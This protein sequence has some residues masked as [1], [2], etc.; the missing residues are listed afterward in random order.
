[1]QCAGSFIHSFSGQSLTVMIQ[2]CHATRTT[3]T[4]ANSLARFPTKI[5]NCL[6]L[7]NVAQPS[8]KYSILVFAPFAA[9]STRTNRLLIHQF[10][11]R[12]RTRLRRKKSSVTQFI[13]RIYSRV[14]DFG[15]SSGSRNTPSLAGT[16]TVV[17]ELL[18]H[19]TRLHPSFAYSLR[20]MT[21]FV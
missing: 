4:T 14:A 2:G 11:S 9:K 19:S 7:A 3:T 12:T 20:R 16:S 1:M 10:K 8:Y 13:S 15:L 17:R 5:N 18:T 21:S 6:A